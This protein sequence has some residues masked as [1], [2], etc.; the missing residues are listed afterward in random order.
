MSVR[1][2]A[3]VFQEVKCPVRKHILGE[4][5][6]PQASGLLQYWCRRCKRMIRVTLHEGHATVSMIND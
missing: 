4:Y 5:Y 1:A 2:G 6:L 3:P